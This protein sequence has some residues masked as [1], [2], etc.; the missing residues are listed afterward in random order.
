M[1]ENSKEVIL[2]KNTKELLLLH[3]RYWQLTTLVACGTS[4]SSKE[5][6]SDKILHMYQKGDKPDNYEEL[7]AQAN[8]NYWKKKT[9]I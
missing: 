2:W 1:E 4:K 6:S 5:G 7:M 3:C 8:K 9:G